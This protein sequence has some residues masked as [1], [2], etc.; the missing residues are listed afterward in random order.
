MRGSC[1]PILRASS[2]SSISNSEEVA[3]LAGLV[4]R[5]VEQLREMGILNV[6]NPEHSLTSEAN[7]RRLLQDNGGNV[8]AV[9]NAIFEQ[10]MDFQ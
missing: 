4:E 7:A 9:A 10:R 2:E 6:A 8:D 5:G 1:F 3:A